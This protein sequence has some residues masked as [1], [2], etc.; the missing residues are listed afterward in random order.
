MKTMM[1]FLWVFLS[2][3]LVLFLLATGGRVL[4][5]DQTETP[6]PPGLEE[7][8]A[9][10]EAGLPLTTTPP[11]TVATPRVEISPT[12][13]V[14]P[15]AEFT[16]TAT[17]PL[18]DSLPLPAVDAPLS[19]TY[20]PVLL[21]QDPPEE[22]YFC[23]QLA[24]SIAIPDNRPAGV[25]D[26]LVIQDP[27]QIIDLNLRLDL[28]HTWVG[29]LTVRLTHQ[30][31]GR[32]IL[33]LDRPGYP[34]SQIGCGG[35]D[36]GAILDDKAS[37]SAEGQC[38]SSPAA[39][40]GIYRPEAALAAFSDE[41]VTGTWVLNVADNSEYDTGRLRG[42]CLAAT[43]AS[44]VPDPAPVSPPA[45]PERASIPGVKGKKQA[46]PLDCEA[47]VAVDWAAFFGVKIDEFEFFS[48]LPGSDNPDLGFVGNVYGA[49]GQ[50]PPN[51]YGV[52]AEPVAALLREYGLTA[53]AH[54]P[55][56]WDDLRAEI[57]AGRPVYVWTIGAASMWSIPVYYTSSDG[58]T[59]IVARY[60]HVVIVTGYDENNVTIVD[61]SSTYVRSKHQFL[62]SW[63]ALN[64]M[65]IT[66][67]P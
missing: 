44:M 50:I 36:I 20:F 28:P 42:W 41:A 2:S 54:R 30:E 37:L 23:S 38:A 21:R 16:P 15:T 51:P 25:S 13:E 39:I 11:A 55:L 61:G 33:L 27:R 17:V 1:R 26:A 45:L 47:R 62:S 66:T 8:T 10:I 60:E 34:A 14:T 67:Q 19:F 40:A 3:G 29:D 49:W 43:L 5:Q 24:Q 9:T 59:S 53:Y 22:V 57:A 6:Q 12:V 56:T 18:T 64:N 4:A 46:M 52:H 32:S 7:L 63:S 65:A 35:D 58:H 31:T 48:R